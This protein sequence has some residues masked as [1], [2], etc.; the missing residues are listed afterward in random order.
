MEKFIDVASLIAARNTWEKK[1]IRVGFVPTMGALHDGHFSLVRAAR[2]LTDRVVVSIF[3]NPTQFGPNEDL[4]SYPSMIEED[5]RAL[6]KEGVDAVFLPTPAVMYPAGFQSYVINSEASL[7]L[8]GGSRPRHFQGVLTV[9]LK[10][11]NLVHPHSAFFGAK[12]YQQLALIRTMARD[13]HLRTQIVSCPTVR[14]EDGLAMS[15]R[16]LRLEAEERELA[17]AIYRGMIATKNFYETGE[18]SKSS[19]LGRFKNEVSDPRFEIDYVEIRDGVTLGAYENMIEPEVGVPHL[20]CAVNL[21]TVRLI[22]NIP[23]E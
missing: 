15:S 14:E 7:V 3:V 6:E 10:L 20:F 17:P 18:R 5:L 12:D 23:L 4:D 2:E 8:C 16:N 22:D 9:V 11:L 13:F 21:G 19:L 1:N